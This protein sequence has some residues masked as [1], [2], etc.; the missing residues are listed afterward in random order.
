MDTRPLQNKLKQTVVCSLYFLMNFLLYEKCLINNDIN[1]RQHDLNINKFSSK[2]YNTY[3]KTKQYQSGKVLQINGT[4]HHLYET[5]H[6]K[7]LQSSRQKEDFD[8]NSVTICHF[9]S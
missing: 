8:G 5:Q 6:L 3:N 4:Q 9:F 7:Q 2:I 1:I